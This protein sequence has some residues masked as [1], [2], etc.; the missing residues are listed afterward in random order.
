MTEHPAG[1]RSYVRS[2]LFQQR[3]VMRFYVRTHPLLEYALLRTL[4][5]LRSYVRSHCSNIRSG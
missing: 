5:T 4:S 2:Q 3:N 1:M